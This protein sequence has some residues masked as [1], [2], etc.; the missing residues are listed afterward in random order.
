[1]KI[2]LDNIGVIK[3]SEIIVDGLTIIAGENSSGKSTIGKSLYAVYNAL[4]KIEIRNKNDKINYAANVVGQIMRSGELI[5][6]INQLRR[7][8]NNDESLINY[9]SKPFVRP[10]TIEETEEQLLSLKK[11][12]IEL[13]LFVLEMQNLS[14]SSKKM[15]IDM[16]EKTKSTS[17]S[18]IDSVL[19][20]FKIDK[21][22]IQY[23]SDWIAK[24]LGAEMSNQ[25]QPYKLDGVKSVIRI[26]DNAPDFMKFSI[27][28]RTRYRVSCKRELKSIDEVFLL[29]NIL[30][31]DLS[32]SSV[33]DRFNV[34]ISKESEKLPTEYYNLMNSRSALKHNNK[35]RYILGSLGNRSVIEESEQGKKIKHIMD[36]LDAI[37]PGQFSSRED[38][39]YYIENQ[40]ELN[41]TNMASGAKLLAMIKILL[42]RGDL[43]E[44]SLLVLDEPECHLHPE[45]QRKLAKIICLMIGDLGVRVVVTTHSPNFMLALD[46]YSLKFKIR[47]KT[48]IYQSQKLEDNYM[49][50]FIEIGDKVDLIYASMAKP[51]LELDAERSKI[52]QDN[53]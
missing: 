18:R 52:L 2:Y 16:M 26:E 17:V 43:D 42:A 39:M 3:N 53:E 49:S 29:D 47:E 7:S 8:A 36:L 24:S 30:D 34:T 38:G 37:I 31:L 51:F 14:E 27:E 25:I 11:N 4:E 35:N 5:Y 48:H 6:V 19:N 20:L 50:S 9:F 41:A 22:M 44:R 23:T 10:N 1:M 21:N 13:S 45:W 46:T 15:M 40:K 32:S 12:L 33:Y 28:N